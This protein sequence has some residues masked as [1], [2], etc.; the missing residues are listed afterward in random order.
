MTAHNREIQETAENVCARW[1]QCFVVPFLCLVTEVGTSQSRADT[2]RFEFSSPES[3]FTFLPSPEGPGLL[4][5]APDIFQCDLAFEGIVGLEVDLGAGTAQFTDVNAVLTGPGPLNG[6]NLANFIDSLVLTTHMADE[7]SVVF[8]HDFGSFGVLDAV[9]TD[10][11]LRIL[12]GFDAT[13]VDGSGWSVDGLGTPVPEP[14]TFTLAL[15]ALLA[16]GHRRRR[17]IRV[18]Q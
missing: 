4:G 12:G 2:L 1:L 8:R 7:T 11:E 13:P 15:L 6:D 10:T 5:C 3:Q 14:S 18:G 9:L 17:Y 16:H